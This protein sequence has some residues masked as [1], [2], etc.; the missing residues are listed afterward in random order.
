MEFYTSGAYLDT[1]EFMYFTHNIFRVAV[2]NLISVA[3]K[4][5]D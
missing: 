5:L 2:K 1:P 3:E 4:P